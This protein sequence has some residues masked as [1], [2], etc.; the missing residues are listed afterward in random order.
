MF[1]PLHAAA[2]AG[3]ARLSPTRHVDQW[4]T[5]QE[6]MPG[7]CLSALEAE[8]TG[9]VVRGTQALRVCLIWQQVKSVAY[10]QANPDVWKV[11]LHA[12]WAVVLG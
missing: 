8:D 11:P 5:D 6:S 12:G 2:S 4:D 7:S 10:N 3:D 9:R 1:L